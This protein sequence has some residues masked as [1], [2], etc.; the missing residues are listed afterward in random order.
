GAVARQGH[1][2]LGQWGIP[3]MLL[4]ILGWRNLRRHGLDRD[5]VAYWAAGALL[6]LPAVLSP[7][8]VRYLYALTLP[9]AVAAA[10]GVLGF[11]R[12][13]AFG[14]ALAAILLAW[15]GLLAGAEIVEAVLH[16]Y[17]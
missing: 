3:A 13:G 5:L 8:D 10:G 17:R 11:V 9:V 14:R 15:Q 6:F 2:A 7:L 4:A 16:R 12:G 1:V